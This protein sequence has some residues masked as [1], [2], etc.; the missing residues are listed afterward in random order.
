MRLKEVPASKYAS[1]V[2]PLTAA[3]WAGPRDLETYVSDNLTIANGR[4]GKRHYR[5]VGL[6]DGKTLVASFK[7]Y[8][9]TMRDDARR[10][11]AVGIGAVFT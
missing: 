1:E 8:E 3:Q 9:R 10:L 11:H 2:L 4:Y 6:Y 7:R 5:T